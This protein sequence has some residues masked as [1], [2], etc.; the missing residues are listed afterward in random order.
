[1]RQQIIV[2]SEDWNASQGILFAF[3][4]KAEKPLFSFPVVLGNKG[5]A[6]GR[7][8]HLY[9]MLS[10]C[11]K[12]EADQKSPAGLFSLGTLFG[13]K[14]PKSSQMS[15][16]PIEP[17]LLCIDDPKSLHYNMMVYKDRVIKEWSSAEEMLRDDG[18]YDLGLVINHNTHPITPGLGSCIFFHLWRNEQTTTAGCTATSY[19]NLLKLAMFLNPIKKPLLL[20][21]PKVA[22]ESFLFSLRNEPIRKISMSRLN[23]LMIP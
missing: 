13:L 1:M 22:Q 9:W 23:A 15:F 20:Q 8:E 2:L 21:I 11:H 4:E 3:E 14:L 18:L 5:M 10:G 16:V 6:W 19:D 7:G 17:N 12:K